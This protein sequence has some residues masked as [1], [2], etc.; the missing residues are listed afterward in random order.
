MESDNVKFNSLEGNQRIY[1]IGL[2]REGAESYGFVMG[3]SLPCYDSPTEAV[4][5]GRKFVEMAGNH[6]NIIR[7]PYTGSTLENVDVCAIDITSLVGANIISRRMLERP[8]DQAVIPK[9]RQAEIIRERM[10]EL[11]PDLEALLPP[12]N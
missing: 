7:G 4:E 8:R 2:K 1:T 12:K 5:D 3:P 9:E 6:S 10:R 11:R